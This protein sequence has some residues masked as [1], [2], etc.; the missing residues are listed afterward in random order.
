MTLAAI[1]LDM[2]GT[3]LN[4][5]QQISEE[6][7]QSLIAAQQQGIKLIL[8]SGRPTKA[9]F[10]YAAQL[11]MDRYHGFLVSYNGSKVTDYAT[12]ESLFDETSAVPTAK[13]VLF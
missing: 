1:I 3:L 7:R 6:T 8:A 2:D 10:A 5:Q 11:K 12:K 9:M 4:E 13:V